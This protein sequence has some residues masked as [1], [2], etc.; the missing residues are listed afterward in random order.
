MH[1]PDVECGARRGGDG[2]LAEMGECAREQNDR[3]GSAKIAPRMASRTLEGDLKTPAAERLRHIGVSSRSI[4]H[5]ERANGLSPRWRA[6]DVPHP[7]EVSLAFLSYISNEDHV[8]GGL[9][10]GSFQG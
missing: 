1:N 8:G 3:V 9:K 7:A 5:K 6:E 2:N 4:N 10:L